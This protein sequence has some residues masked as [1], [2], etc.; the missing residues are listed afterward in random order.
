MIDI[1]GNMTFLYVGGS[2]FMVMIYYYPAGEKTF[3]N[4][5]WEITNE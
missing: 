2:L 4:I 3:H 1:T 5:I